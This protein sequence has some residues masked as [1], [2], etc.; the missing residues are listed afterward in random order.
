MDATHNPDF[1][2]LECYAAYKNYQD[3]MDMTEKLIKS[4]I[5]DVLP[6]SGF[7]IERDGQIIGFQQ[8]FVRAEMTELIKNTQA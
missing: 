8:K 1:T 5:T 6:G 7:Q 3:F 2:M 4:L